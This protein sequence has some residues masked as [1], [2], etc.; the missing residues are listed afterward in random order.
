MLYPSGVAAEAHQN[1]PDFFGA[2]AD[3]RW[4][5]SVSMFR[6]YVQFVNV[7]LS[8]PLLIVIIMNVTYTIQ[9]VCVISYVHSL[10]SINLYAQ[11]A[12]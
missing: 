9:C 8:L 2:R 11:S 5:F 10:L 7:K 3:S 6:L 4:A 12:Y 1:Q